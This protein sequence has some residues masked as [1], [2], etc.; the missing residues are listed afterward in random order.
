MGA[1]AC[2]HDGCNP[3][4]PL[5]RWREVFDISKL[6]FV[7]PK[8]FVHLESE[9]QESLSVYTDLERLREELMSKAPERVAPASCP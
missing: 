3:A 4:Q 5:S 2:E 7:Y 6:T 8:E 9:G 1:W